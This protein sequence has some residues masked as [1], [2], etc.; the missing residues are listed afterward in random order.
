MI[1]THRILL[2]EIVIISYFVNIKKKI[3]IMKTI[4][5]LELCGSFCMTVLLG[6]IAF[7]FI[8]L[9]F[10]ILYLVLR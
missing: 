6:I 4:K 8:G 9:F 5:N 3:K 10:G 1:L 7:N 2:M